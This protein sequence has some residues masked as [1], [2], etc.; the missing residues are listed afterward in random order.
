[1][2]LIQF[3]QKDESFQ[4]IS[5]NVSVKNNSTDISE[6]NLSSGR[7]LWLSLDKVSPSTSENAQRSARMRHTPV[8]LVLSNCE[9]NIR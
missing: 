2:D 6:T 5:E 9:L 8:M 1:L 7:D 3:C 4:S